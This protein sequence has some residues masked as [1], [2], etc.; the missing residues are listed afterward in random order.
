M[1]RI[2]SD[3]PTLFDSSKKIKIK[4]EKEEITD[5]TLTKVSE[6]TSFKIYTEVLNNRINSILKLLDNEFVSN[7]EKDDIKEKLKSIEF[8]LFEMKKLEKKL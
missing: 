1:D 5:L 4:V 2:F 6:L 7:D 8:C 3:N